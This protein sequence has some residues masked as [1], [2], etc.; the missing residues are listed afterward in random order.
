MSLTILLRYLLFVCKKVDLLSKSSVYNLYTVV[1]LFVRSVKSFSRS[2]NF[3]LFPALVVPVVETET[4]FELVSFVSPSLY[5][6][7]S[8]PSRFVDTPFVVSFCIGG[9]VENGRIGFLNV[10]VLPNEKMLP[11]SKF[12][13]I[14]VPVKSPSV[15][16]LPL[17]SFLLS[18]ERLDIKLSKTFV[19]LFDADTLLVLV[20]VL[21]LVSAFFSL[22]NGVVFGKIGIL[23]FTFSSEN[24]SDLDNLLIIILYNQDIILLLLVITVF[25]MNM[26]Y[27][28]INYLLK[29]H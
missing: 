10:S 29:D 23:G 13:F 24:K 4:E 2:I 14:S 18:N 22:E 9:L 26:H 3:W 5:E 17:V 28:K 16:I 11:C 21:V 6:T 7:G 15:S 1:Y 12:K 19:A 8:K 27:W 20:L 25:L